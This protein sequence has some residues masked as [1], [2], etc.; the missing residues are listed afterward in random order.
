MGEALIKKME[1]ETYSDND[2]S[3]SNSIDD[4]SKIQVGFRLPFEPAAAQD[5]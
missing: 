4:V 3:Q 2:A 5:V 1:G